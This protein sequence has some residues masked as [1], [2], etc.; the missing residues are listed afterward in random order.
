MSWTAPRNP[1]VQGMAFPACEPPGKRTMS[2][3]GKLIQAK[4]Q[5]PFKPG[6]QEG[7]QAMWE[8]RWSLLGPTGQAGWFQRH[9]VLPPAQCPLVHTPIHGIRRRLSGGQPSPFGI[10]LRRIRAAL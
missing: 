9:G 4:D 3:N 5:V 2:R 6:Y 7:L 10:A 1:P 8:E